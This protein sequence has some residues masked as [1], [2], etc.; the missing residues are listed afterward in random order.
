[1]FLDAHTHAFHPKIADKVLCKLQDHYGIETVG[2]G[3]VDDLLLRAKRAG[4][5]KVVVHCAATAAAQVVPA[6]AFAI[7]LR[8]SH[9]EIIPFGT[10][11]PDCT[12]WKAQLDRLRAA[13][14]HGLK[15]HPEFQG[16]WLNDPRLLPIIEEAQ[17]DFVFMCHIGDKVRPEE[18][19]SCP[20]KLAAL[21]DAFPDARFIAAHFGGFMHWNYALEVLAGRRVWV[22]TSSSLEFIE[23]DTLRGFL[24]KHP[25]ECI[26]FGSD[27]PLYDPADEYHRLQQRTGY[28]DDVMEELLSNAAV[29]LDAA[30]TSPGPGLQDA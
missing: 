25:R 12:D 3:L 7:E 11:H 26:L 10:I 9:S 2:T 22:D 21:L 23:E 8:K 5:D 14:I 6:N 29:L 1:M 19:P 17:R 13:G 16:F 28:S 30:T 20:Y 18:N 27:Y 15:L 4:L 24:K